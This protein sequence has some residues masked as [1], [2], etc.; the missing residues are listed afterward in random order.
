TA[1]R[2]RHGTR[3]EMRNRTRANETETQRLCH[4]ALLARSPGAQFV[5][6]QQT[7]GFDLAHGPAAVG[8]CALHERRRRLG[9]VGH[10]PVQ[11]ADEIP[12]EER[13]PLTRRGFV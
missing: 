9:Y 13:P 10:R 1:L 4:S 7:R 8:T 12:V 3:V 5:S 6:H 11:I 2:C